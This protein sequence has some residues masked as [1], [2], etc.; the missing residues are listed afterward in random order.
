MH[1]FHVNRYIFFASFFSFVFSQFCVFFFSPQKMHSRNK[2]YFC[3]YSHCSVSFILF[4]F[5]VC[6]CNICCVFVTTRNSCIFFSQLLIVLWKDAVP[7]KTVTT[8]NKCLSFGVC[9]TSPSTSDVSHSRLLFTG[10][11]QIWYTA[12]HT[13]ILLL[14]LKAA[15]NVL[16]S[17]VMFCSLLYSTLYIYIHMYL[18]SSFVHGPLTI[19]TSWSASSSSLLLWFFALFSV[20]KRN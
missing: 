3:C 16:R 15:I 6:I 1:D 10:N 12:Q 4:S 20:F 2:C 13:N 19:W 8:M 17:L 9:A 5:F 18:W 11:A 14:L 7:C